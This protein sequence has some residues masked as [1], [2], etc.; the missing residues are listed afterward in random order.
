[1]ISFVCTFAQGLHR[2]SKTSQSPAKFVAYGAEVNVTRLSDFPEKSFAQ[3]MCNDFEAPKDVAVCLGGSARSFPHQL[4]QR[5][6]KENLLGGSFGVQMTP[7]LHVTRIDAR[8]DPFRGWHDLFPEWREDQLRS[9]AHF[10]NIA[11]E[12][13]KIIDGPDFPLPTCTQYKEDF[14]RREQYEAK[15]L[16]LKDPAEIKNQKAT[17]TYV[18]ALAGSLSHRKG[19]M[20]LISAK[21]RKRSLKFDIV[22][23]ARPDLTYYLPLQPYCLYNLDQA[24]RSKDWLFM[25][26]RDEAEDQFVK[27]YKDFYDCKK[28]FAFDEQVEDYLG[29]PP[30]DDDYSFPVIV[31]RR[32]GTK[33]SS[34]CWHGVM[35]IDGMDL[36]DLCHYSYIEHNEYNS[37][38]GA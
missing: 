37:Y 32:N 36:G 26:P 4:V 29:G 10:L 2:T 1:M 20:D 5:S 23:V 24:S 9:A 21:E 30:A 8:G 16:P 22:I 31:T 18:K 19:C 35:K 13:I 11:D 34:L 15:T 14:E 33:A 38:H 3:M 28:P 25:V 6:V 7:F 17:L 27:R 12:D